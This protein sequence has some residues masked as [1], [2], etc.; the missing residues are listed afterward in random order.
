MQKIIRDTIYTYI[1]IRENI[2]SIIDSESFQRLKYIKQLTIQHLYPSANHTR[3][4]HS[5]GVM[6]LALLVFERIKGDISNNQQKI[7]SKDTADEPFKNLNYLKDHLLYASLLHDVGHAPFSHVGEIFYSKKNIL[8]EIGKEIELIKDKINF[9]IEFLNDE[10]IAPHELMSCYVIIKKFLDKLKPIDYTPENKKNITIDLEFIFRIICGKLYEGSRDSTVSFIKN[11][12]IKI[13]NSDTIDVDKID[14]LL[15]DN[16][17]VGYIGPQLDID[18]LIMS[19]IV[20]D[21][22]GLTFSHTGISALQGL[23]DCRNIL[24][25]WIFN[26]HTVVYTD[27]LY[28]KCFIRFT[29]FNKSNSGLEDMPLSSLFSCKAIAD[30]CV[31]DVDA[32]SMINKVYKSAKNE[33]LS[34]QYTFRLVNQLMNRNF[35]KPIWKTLN[36][37]NVF[38]A[39]CGYRTDEQKEKLAAYINNWRNRMQLVFDISLKLGIKRGNLFIIKRENKFFEKILDNLAVRIDNKRVLIKDSL[40]IKEY[41]KKYQK[42]A[43]YVYCENELIGDVET[44]LKNKLKEIKDHGP[45]MN[46]E[47]F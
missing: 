7:L 22:D 15:R 38:L 46:F 14:Y 20:H 8:L 11:I 23:I 43:F 39:D 31:S 37:Y 26:H 9:S 44:E 13:V 29:K 19:M 47:F 41:E 16:K 1:V 18:R 24:Y 2:K 30:D 5:L 6:H 32:L 35:L 40:P 34:S 45:Q 17:M 42:T 33:T 21:L 10:K 4:E 12:I 25:L 28:Q 27:Y 36:Q 3:F